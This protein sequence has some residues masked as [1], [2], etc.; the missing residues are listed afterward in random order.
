MPVSKI[1]AASPF[2]PLRPPTPTSMHFLHSDGPDED[3][4]P[5]QKSLAQSGPPPSSTRSR[6]GSRAAGSTLGHSNLA[7]RRPS[8]AQRNQLQIPAP[9]SP[10]G[11]TQ[12]VIN[13]G[14]GPLDSPA[15]LH[16]P[17]SSHLI[18]PFN[19]QAS[20][21]S[22]PTSATSATSATGLIS[23]PSYP[24][25]PISTQPL[26]Q[27]L[28][29]PLGRPSTA[30]EQ[31]VSIAGNRT[32]PNQ[33]LD[34]RGLPHHGSSV[35]S[36]GL[37]GL[38]SSRGSRMFHPYAGGEPSGITRSGQDLPGPSRRASVPN[39][40]MSSHHLG[41]VTAHPPSP[42]GDP[43]VQLRSFSGDYAYGPP[44]PNTTWS[45][46]PSSGASRHLEREGL[47]RQTTEL[48]EFS[49]QPYHS[50]PTQ[51]PSLPQGWSESPSRLASFDHIPA[52]S[53]YVYYPGQ[54]S[55]YEA[56]RGG[57][58]SAPLPLSSSAVAAANDAYFAQGGGGHHPP[59]PEP[60]Y[61][62]TGDQSGSGRGEYQ[63]H[64]SSS[65][66]PP[67]PTP[68]LMAQHSAATT[69]A[70]IPTPNPPFAALTMYAPMHEE[71]G[72]A[73]FGM[74]P[75][76]A[77]GRVGG[78]SG[79]DGY[80]PLLPREV[81]QHALRLEGEQLWPSSGTAV[82][83]TSS[84]GEVRLGGRGS[85]QGSMVADGEEQTRYRKP[86]HMVGEGEEENEVT[87]GW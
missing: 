22:P 56:R 49:P 41:R 53:H 37:R 15:S 81:T 50:A 9:L 73:D 82:G 51:P 39:L 29:H 76:A 47:M 45:Y 85:Q 38:A 66:N 48:Q 16:S 4:S 8:F 40:R 25:I 87:F 12:V 32:S 42:F 52:S 31:P 33:E 46:F 21:S 19:N 26:P 70:S 44:P 79:T 7:S 64:S 14:A 68:P 54:V 3:I 75:R 58:P 80:E 65:A 55:P 11:Q 2:L 43:S 61:F 27:S 35:P 78:R 34:Y 36:Q 83:S 28:S 6:R 18:D 74:A 69:Y 60:W 24:S 5:K 1:V 86:S 77:D 63:E 72:P 57:P 17:H 84:A 67:P 20:S 30:T 59:A 71:P 62:S 10:H 13:G 23:R